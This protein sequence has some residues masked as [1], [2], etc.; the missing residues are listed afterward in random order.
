MRLQS[1]GHFWLECDW[2]MLEQE[3]GALVFGLRVSL[4]FGS[5]R[6]SSF[7]MPCTALTVHRWLSSW[8]DFGAKVTL[9]LTSKLLMSESFCQWVPQIEQ[10]SLL[11]LLK[12]KKKTKRRIGLLHICLEYVLLLSNPM[13]FIFFYLIWQNPGWSW[14]LFLPPPPLIYRLAPPHLT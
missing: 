4:V 13:Y 1:C 7:I 3:A 14:T 9:S 12:K 2:L 5:H 6:P 8:P 11:L 10:L